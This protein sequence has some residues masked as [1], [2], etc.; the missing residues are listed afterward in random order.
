[1]RRGSSRHVESVAGLLGDA[2]VR[3]RQMAVSTLAQHGTAIVDTLVQTLRDQHRDLSVLSSAL[4]LLSVSD[5]DIVEPVIRFL[6]DE[7]TNLRIQAALILGQRRDRRAIA[8]L[9]ARL[10]R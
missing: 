6:D 7:D 3:V 8:P 1:M 9:V 5:I 4:D 10:R 2:N